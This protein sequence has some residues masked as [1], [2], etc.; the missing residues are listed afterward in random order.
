M[1]W[2]AVL[3]AGSLSAFVPAQESGVISGIVASMD[4]RPLAGAPV[5]VAGTT[6]GDH[7]DAEGRFLITGVPAGARVVRATFP[8]YR[9]GR[10]RVAIGAD[11]TA[12][13]ALRLAPARA[14]DGPPVWRIDPDARPRAIPIASPPSALAP[15][16]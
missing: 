16:Q 10:Y 3:A 12:R 1:K 8:G 13:I 2:I 14:A 7:T 15:E 4:G 11:D 6:R 5:A 9:E